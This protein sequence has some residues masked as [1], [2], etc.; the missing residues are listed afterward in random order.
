ML[1]SRLVTKI[2][3][4]V[5]AEWPDAWVFKVHGS[6]YQMA[7]VPDLLVVV[8]GRLYAFEVKC[9]KAGESAHHARGRASLVQR[10]QID[11]LRRAGAVADVILT[12]EEA[13]QLIK[14]S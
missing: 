3:Q 13:L 12:P 2:I 5:K 10:A 8:D 14:G 6:P 9:R 4:A 1:E 11:Q 7:G